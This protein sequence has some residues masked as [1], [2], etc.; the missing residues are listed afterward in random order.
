VKFYQ[1]AINCELE[2]CEFEYGGKRDGYGSVYISET[3]VSFEKC[4][5]SN[6]ILAIK[7]ENKGAFE[8]FDNN[9]FSNITTYP[10]SIEPA[11][12]HTIGVN[13]I[14][15]SN[16]SIYIDGDVNFDT[17]GEFTWKNQ[18]IPFVFDGSMR[19]GTKSTQGLKLTIDPGVVINMTTGSYIDF[20]YWDNEYV[21]LVAKGTKEKPI[22]FTSNSPSKKAGD[23]K[24]L[25]FYQGAINCEL[26]Y[27]EFEYGGS[28]ESYGSIYIK[29]TEVSFINC[30]ISNS[31]S[32]GI[33]LEDDA[34]FTKF[35]NNTLN[36]NT[37]YPI[38]IYP[39][40]VY[41]IGTD[42]VYDASIYIDNSENLTV[43]GDFTWLNQGVPYVIS[44]LMRIGSVNGTTINISAGTVL[45][46]TK[47]SAIDVSYWDSENAKLIVNGTASNPVLFTSNSP[48]PR[49]G[50]W[51]GIR[52]YNGVTGSKL[53]Y[54][55]I[56]YAGGNSYGAVY[57]S[58]SGNNT[59]TI[60]NSKISNSSSY[61]ISVDDKSSVDYSTVTFSNNDDIDY[62][63]R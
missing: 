20:A 37:L 11:S 47:G 33:L 54:C 57:L 4:S 48:V 7:L 36:N 58:D 24:S 5:F 50:D 46:F 14:Y 56:E 29:E 63:V 41:S 6:S 26:E 40:A 22:V 18:G 60:Q 9:S 49:K 31:A 44:G 62:K 42:N 16:S 13:N 59:V 39:N 53:S 45:K 52:F 38:N 25:S 17:A 61:G 27:C 21:T 43:S 10:I 15:D 3:S 2:Y 1:G 23:W 55:N 8:H 32:Y 34:K 30:K 19:V 28:S 12:V 51:N 35:E